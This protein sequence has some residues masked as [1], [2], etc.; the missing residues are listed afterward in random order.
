MKKL[1]NSIT[2]ILLK[3]IIPYPR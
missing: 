1:Y 3:L 2:I